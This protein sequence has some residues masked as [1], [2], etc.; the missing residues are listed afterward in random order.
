MGQDKTSSL[1]LTF[2]FDIG[3]ASVGWAVLNPARIVALGVRGFDRAEDEKGRPLNEQRRLMRTARN[4]LKRRALRLEKL[5]RAMRDAGLISGADISLLFTRTANGTQVLTPWEARARGLDQRLEPGDWARALYHIVKHRGFYAARKSETLDDEKEGGKLAKGVRRTEQLMKGRWRTIGE[6]AAKDEQFAEHKRNKAGSYENSFA[7]KLLGEELRTLFERQRAL[8]NPH[9]SSALEEQVFELFSWQKPALTGAAMLELIGRCTFEPDEYRAPKRGWSAERFV[10]L[11][12]LNTVTVVQSGE[13]RSLTDG[14]RQAAIDLPYRR[15][16]V[17]YRQLRKAIGLEDAS[18]AGF[19]GLSYGSKR[20]KKGEIVDPEEAT[21]IELKGWHAL[22][23]AL[24]KASLAS[25]WQRVSAEPKTMDAIALAL[26]TYKDDEEL[27]PELSKL[28]LETAE[29]EAILTLDFKDFIRLSAK[30]IEKLLPHLEAGKRY[31]DACALAG[32]NHAK[33]ASDKNRVRILPPLDY[34]D[35]RNPVVF[36]ALNQA[37]KVLNAL[38]RTYGSPCAVHVELARDLS[39][40]WEER[41]EIRKGQ[42]AYREQRDKALDL[43]KETFGRTPVARDRRDL[44]KFRLYNDQ[45]GKCAYSLQALDIERVVNDPSYAQIDHALPYSRSFDD[46]QNNKVLVLASENQNKG[47]RTPFEYLDGANESP[48][49]RAF[50]AWVRGLRTFRKAKRDRLLRRHFDEK[51]AAGFK[52]RN[53]NDTRYITRYFAELVRNNLVFAPDET[54]EVK[55][56]PVLAPAGRFTSFLRARWGLLKNR[57]SSDLH[58]ALDACVIAAASPSL[59]KRVSDFARRNELVQLPDGT[60]ADRET[61]EILSPQKA[62]EL[63]DRFPQPW[64]MFRDEVLARLSDNPRENVGDR[65]NSYD[66]AVLASLKPILVSRAVKRRARGAAHEETIRSVASHLGP[67]TS[68]GRVRLEALKLSDLEDIVGAAD[69]RNAGL[70]AAIRQRL[71]AHKG[72]GKKAFGPT[73]EPL[74]KPRR[75]GTPGPVVRAVKLKSVQ[76]GG[77]SVRGGVADQ[78]NMWRVDVFRKAGRYHLVPIYQ[79]DRGKGSTPPNRAVVAYAPRSEWTPID[80]SYDFQFSLH[81][82]DLVQLKTKKADYFG[83]YIGMNVST[84]AITIMS[85]NRDANLGKAGV[86]ESL[87]VKSSVETFRKFYVDSLGNFYPAKPQPRY[88]LA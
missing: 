34:R 54:G 6:M 24:E 5:R 17:T 52:E 82:N 68:S 45:G 44:E 73:T 77:V 18:D 78:A 42:N 40:P 7:R 43:F 29:I 59:I 49:W 15:A 53:L 9:S 79:S 4:R 19:A 3:M 21:L 33:P 11:S 63:G 60:F 71:E 32:Y 65:F 14:E 81:P 38:V 26:S 83:Y 31:D 22:R 16:K 56:I 41:M 66:E 50:E 75:D 10:W 25:T 35:I 28:G 46:S 51:E 12:K 76:K 13:R 58:H 72:D 69:G 36:R 23:I 55:K 8:G 67:N 61:G 37:R 86:W 84:A 27:R 39:K 74:R 57:E 70:I 88:G 47:N 1:P 87:G 30:A 2:G 64:P 62:A 85:S 80:A 48:R 20:N